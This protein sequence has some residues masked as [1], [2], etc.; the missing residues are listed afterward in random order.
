MYA[1]HFEKL[2]KI[3]FLNLLNK[4]RSDIHIS[5]SLHKDILNNYRILYKIIT[6]EQ[7]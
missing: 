5:K 2:K 7:S 6:G 4:L 1:P 3:I